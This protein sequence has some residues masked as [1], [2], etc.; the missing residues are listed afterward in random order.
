MNELVTC[1][2][3]HGEAK[4]IDKNALIFRPAAYAIVIHED[5][6][7]MTVVRSTGK[8]TLPGGG[9]DIGERMEDALKRELKEECGIEIEII[10]PAFFK[11]TF[12]YYEPLD[13]AWQCHSFCFLC[14]PLSSNLTDEL[15]EE[16][17]ESI[18]P[19]WVDLKSLTLQNI[20]ICGEEI[21][22]YIKT[23]EPTE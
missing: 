7:L 12:F 22:R 11:E 6:L 10:T 2:T 16:E 17:D 13:R 9:I 1:Y 21:L 8:Y 15:N 18:Q 3:M 19:Q 5:K 4:Q 23:L 20:Q 14:K